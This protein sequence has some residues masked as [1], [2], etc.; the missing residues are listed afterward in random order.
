MKFIHNLFFAILLITICGF[1]SQA[2]D[3][4]RTDTTQLSP[5]SERMADMMDSTW[6]EYLRAIR[7]TDIE[8]ELEENEVVTF[9]DSIYKYRIQQLNL[10][11]PFD[12]VWNESVQNSIHYFTRRRRRF[13]S[14]CMARSEMFFPMY[15]EKLKKYNMPIELKYLSVVESGLRP[16][17]K[18][19][20]GAMGLWQ[21]MYRTGKMFG[22]E[23]NSYV[24]MRRDPE[25]AT[26]AACQYLTYL[27]K[28]Y[29]DWSM[30][31]AA[32]NAG[33]GNVNKAIRRSG[34]RMTYWEI[35]DHL[36][37][38]TQ[39]YV[40]SFIAT[41]YMMEYAQEHNIRP[42]PIRFYDF[43]TDT[44]C[45]QKSLFLGHVDSLVGIP[46]E[47][48]LYLNPIFEGE[49]IPIN[50]EVSY[51]LRMPVDKISKFLEW[52]DSLYAMTEKL[53]ESEDEDSF[54]ALEK[55]EYHYVKSG[56]NLGFIGQRYG[57][58]VNEIMGWNN[59]SSTR[60]RVGQ[61]LIIRT[62]GK[63][64]ISKE[65]KSPKSKEKEEQPYKG[66]YEYY[67]IKS[68]DNLWDISQAKNV[69]LKDIESLNP[70]INSGNLKVGQKI[71]I[72]AP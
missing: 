14:L 36:P 63:K 38:E 53:E 67:T 34:G 65:K 16:T 45:I 23:N 47:D 5:V 2:E 19:R 18:S 60:L 15:E 61:K 29:D 20:A 48:M 40:P 41:V 30:A 52:E 7:K 68:G 9:D 56:E 28:L 31:L 13:I 71:K 8:Y 43:E 27:H 17:A 24:D 66:K 44:V 54:L 64:K 26:E 1:H 12:F 50:D 22:L 33:P 42:A 58:S 51:C 25:L 62:T 72:P 59:L 49:Y 10:V 35:R 6:I 3:T 4:L 39:N 55:K 46:V 32:Y 70:G 11:T 69:N 37:R 57:V 21:F